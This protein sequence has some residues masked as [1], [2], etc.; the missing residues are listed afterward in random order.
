MI[1]FVPTA[2]LAFALIASGAQAQTAGPTSG[3]QAEKPASPAVAL[4]KNAALSTLSAREPEIK[5]IYVDEDG[6]TVAVSETKV[7]D[8]PVTRIIMAEA[9]LRTDRSDKPRRFLCLLGEN[10]K[11]LLTFFTAR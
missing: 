11:V 10:D 1:R 8:T 2:L 6:A 7:E 4:C 3:A 5:D 9:Y